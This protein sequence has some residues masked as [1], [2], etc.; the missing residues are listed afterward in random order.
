MLGINIEAASL[1][2]QSLIDPVI[3][4]GG[5][6]AMADIEQLCAVESEGVEN[7]SAVARSTRRSRLRAGASPR[8][9]AARCRRAPAVRQLALGVG[10]SSGAGSRSSLGQT[11]NGKTATGKRQTANGRARW[12]PVA[13]RLAMPSPAW[14]GP[15]PWR[16]QGHRRASGYGANGR[17]RLVP[18][19]APYAIVFMLLR[20][21]IEVLQWC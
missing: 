11:A 7:R 19:P 14:P 4:S 15:V 3:A 20:A 2:A 10:V 18:H 5:L 8:R 12:R 6:S 1:L 21:P 17:G 16:Y 13:R 9:R